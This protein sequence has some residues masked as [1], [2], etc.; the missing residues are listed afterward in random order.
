[1]EV[2]VGN[3][4]IYVYA[5]KKSRAYEKKSYLHII[6]QSTRHKTICFGFDFNSRSAV[7]QWGQ[8]T[9]TPT[10]QCNVFFFRLC[11]HLTLT[12]TLSCQLKNDWLLKTGLFENLWIHSFRKKFMTAQSKRVSVI[13]FRKHA[14]F[15]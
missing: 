1:M 11:N 6:F 2:H 9:T 8:L 14:F 3:M 13:N 4:H 15:T 5:K 10:C 7:Q 12:N